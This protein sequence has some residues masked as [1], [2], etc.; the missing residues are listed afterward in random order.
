MLKYALLHMGIAVI[1]MGFEVLIPKFLRFLDS[2]FFKTCW[3]AAGLSFSIEVCFLELGFRLILVFKACFR[4]WCFVLWMVL[5]A[6]CGKGFHLLIPPLSSAADCWGHVEILT[7]FDWLLLVLFCFPPLMSRHAWV[8]Q[9]SPFASI[10]YCCYYWLWIVLLWLNLW[11]IATPW[12]RSKF[13]SDHSRG[14]N[15]ND[16]VLSGLFWPWCISAGAY[17]GYDVF[18]GPLSLSTNATLW[19]VD[20]L[21]FY[22]GFSPPLLWLSLLQ[23]VGV[24]GGLRC[25]T[26]LVSEIEWNYKWLG[27]AT[28]DWKWL[29]TPSLAGYGATGS[30]MEWWRLLLDATNCYTLLLYILMSIWRILRLGLMY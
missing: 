2:G 14:C 25:S 29:W 19:G 18:L 7:N 8:E 27:F 13:W 6:L 28:W 3:V 1:L 21:P 22:I 11:D 17:L 20:M 4:C 16:G 26:L 5:V 23:H 15:S 10:L 24:E 12:R 9:G 30:I